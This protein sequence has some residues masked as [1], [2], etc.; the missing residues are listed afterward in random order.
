MIDLIYQGGALGMTTVLL[1]GLGA[2]IWALISTIK[3]LKLGFIPKRH[4]DAILFLGSF[5][6]F[7]GVFWQGVGLSGALS[8]IQNL[9]SISPTTV[10]GGIRVSM[11]PSLTGAVLFAIAGLLWIILHYKNAK[12]ME[13]NEA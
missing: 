13:A 5:S 4:L 2:I 12:K 3:F 10:A 6:F 7:I 9:K 1:S 8:I 11:I